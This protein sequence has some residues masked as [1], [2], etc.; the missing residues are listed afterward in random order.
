MVFNQFF[1][2]K[3]IFDSKQMKPLHYNREYS[4]HLLTFFVCKMSK[5]NTDNYS[6]YLCTCQKKNVLFDVGIVERENEKMRTN[7]N[8]KKYS[9]LCL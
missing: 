3:N 5:T 9:Y 1:L 8:I 4:C 2:K 6:Y 7:K